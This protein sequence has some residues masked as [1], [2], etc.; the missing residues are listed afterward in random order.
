MNNTVSLRP[1]FPPARFS[2]VSP[3]LCPAV[4]QCDYSIC[5]CVGDLDGVNL[6]EN[7]EFDFYFSVTAHRVEATGN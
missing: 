2:S 1:A 4:P 3:F 7:P 6:F 5:S